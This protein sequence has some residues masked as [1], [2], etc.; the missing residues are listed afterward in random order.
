MRGGRSAFT[1]AE[2]VD[3]ASSAQVVPVQVAVSNCDRLS[4]SAAHHNSLR[5]PGDFSFNQ[6][7]RKKDTIATDTRASTCQNLASTTMGDDYT[8]LAHDA[9]CRLVD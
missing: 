9:Q 4:I 8:H 7:R 5:T 1:G 6:V 3:V 2:V